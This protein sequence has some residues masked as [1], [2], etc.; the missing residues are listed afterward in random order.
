MGSRIEEID[1]ICNGGA[2]RKSI[3]SNTGAIDTSKPTNSVQMAEHISPSSTSLQCH[4]RGH[5]ELAE[6]G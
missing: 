4:K 5:F 1:D 3:Q 6:H 2:P